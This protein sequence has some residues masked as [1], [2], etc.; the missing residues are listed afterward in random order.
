MLAL[1]GGKEG[2]NIIRAFLEQARG[3]LAPGGRVALEIGAGQADMLMEHLRLL[4]Y[5]DARVT[6]DYAGINRFLFATHG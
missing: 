3:Y 5:K 2:G 4:G 1:D 6:A